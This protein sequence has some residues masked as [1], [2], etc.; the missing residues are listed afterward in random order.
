MAELTPEKMA[1]VTEAFINYAGRYQ[2]NKDTDEDFLQ[3][4]DQFSKNELLEML[5]MIAWNCNI[6]RIEEELKL[7]EVI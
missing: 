7:S 3:A 2:N 5:G 6:E 4:M 1:E